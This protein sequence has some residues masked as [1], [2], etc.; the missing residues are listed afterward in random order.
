MS[1]TT[2]IAEAIARRNL[3]AEQAKAKSSESIKARKTVKGQRNATK[4]RETV[5]PI[6]EQ[7]ITGWT[8]PA[9]FKAWTKYNCDAQF[10]S[11]TSALD[12]GRGDI[13]VAYDRYVAEVFGAEIN[14]VAFEKIV[15]R[16]IARERQGRANLGLLGYSAED[17]VQMAVDNARARS[18][19]QYLRGIGAPKDEARLIF[20]A[21]T[22]RRTNEQLEHDSQLSEAV[23]YVFDEKSNRIRTSNPSSGVRKARRLLATREQMK[24]DA[25]L[26]EVADWLPSVGAVYREI[27]A[28]IYAGLRAFK[29][30]SEGL[31]FDGV[32]D[33]STQFKVSME[34]VNRNL[35]FGQLL[36]KSVESELFETYTFTEDVEFDLRREALLATLHAKE[37]E[38][39]PA[40]VDAYTFVELLQVEKFNLNEVKEVFADMSQ[41]KFL[42]LYREAQALIESLDETPEYTIHLRKARAAYLVG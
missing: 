23:R 18:I 12:A 32:I 38:L 17:I 30:V 31:T 25:Q 19:E 22:D 21:M 41:R 4:K 39:L 7:Y 37:A 40:E 29:N 3:L 24:Q 34:G 35:E 9:P 1:S 15:T 14:Q 20:L 27:G 42:G 10:A 33:D 2:R 36:S 28:V 13:V 11:F 6:D 5:T 8:L 26:L 16:Q